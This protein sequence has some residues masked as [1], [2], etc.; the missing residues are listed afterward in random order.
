MQAI[1]AVFDGVNFKPQ[2]EVPV[3]GQYEVIITFTKQLSP[4]PINMSQDQ[5]DEDISFWKEFDRLVVDA[6][7]DVLSLDDFSRTKFNRQLLTFEDGV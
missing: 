4:N 7:D 3:S 5:L 1:K 6:N 2:Q